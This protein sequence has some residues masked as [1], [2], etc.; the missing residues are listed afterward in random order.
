MNDRQWSMEW[1]LTA[2]HLRRILPGHRMKPGELTW[3]HNAARNHM[4]TGINSGCSI[5]IAGE[6]AR[7]K[8]FLMIFHG[9]RMP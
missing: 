7:G 5:E 8:M 1:T 3:L 9:E 4:Q 2:A 6:L